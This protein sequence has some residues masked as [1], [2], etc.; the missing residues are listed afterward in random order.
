[1]R[2]LAF[3]LSR[4]G[5]EATLVIALLEC[6][7]SGG[8]RGLEGLPQA[9][10]DGR[11]VAVSMMLGLIALAYLALLMETVAASGGARYAALPVYGAS[12]SLLSIALAAGSL[13]T[14]NPQLSRLAVA[15]HAGGVSLCL[16]GFAGTRRAGQKLLGLEGRL[17]GFLYTLQGLPL[18][19]PLASSAIF[20]F[21]PRGCPGTS[22]G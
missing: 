12:A 14:H 9:L 11:V 1:M 18:L 19:G 3:T 15:F 20:T 4:L 13:A 5:L 2:L 16:A 17:W 10:G 8:C 6:T 22:P 21:S 7:R